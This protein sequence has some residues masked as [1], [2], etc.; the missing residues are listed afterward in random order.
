MLTINPSCA[1]EGKQVN[2]VRTARHVRRH[3]VKQ[4]TIILSQVKALEYGAT[5]DPVTLLA[6]AMMRRAKKGIRWG[7]L[8]AIARAGSIDTAGVVL[9]AW[10]VVFGLMHRCAERQCTPIDDGRMGVTAKFHHIVD[11]Y[12]LPVTSTPKHVIYRQ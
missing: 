5:L 11:L 9:L 7:L 6:P 12:P 10:R 8:V 3:V 1:V 2:F 4:R